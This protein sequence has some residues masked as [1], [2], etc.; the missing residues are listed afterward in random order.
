MT[1]RQGWK[2]FSCQGKL[3]HARRRYPSVPSSNAGLTEGSGHS[4]IDFMTDGGERRF[5]EMVHPDVPT[6]QD[7]EGMT[8][9]Q[10]CDLLSRA[11]RS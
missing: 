4:G 6:Q 3:W 11:P 8:D 9:A 7:L 1:P 2:Q 5:L 10:L